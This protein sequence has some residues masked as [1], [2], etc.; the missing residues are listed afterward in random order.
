MVNVSV[1]SVNDAMVQ[2]FTLRL[3]DIVVIFSQHSSLMATL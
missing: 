3:T 1:N 2:D